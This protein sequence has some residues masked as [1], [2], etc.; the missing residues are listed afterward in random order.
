[1]RCTSP[2]SAGSPF[3]FGVPAVSSISEPPRRC[4]SRTATMGY[5]ESR[6]LP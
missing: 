4:V 6:A 3:A 1:M 2:S 5:L